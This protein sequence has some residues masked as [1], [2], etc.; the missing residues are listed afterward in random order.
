MC[1]RVPQARH[2]MISI[3]N[4]WLALSTLTS[5]TLPSSMVSTRVTWLLPYKTRVFEPQL[6][7][8]HWRFSASMT[9]ALI[10]SSQRNVLVASPILQV[11]RRLAS[12]QLGAEQRDACSPLSPGRAVGNEYAP[13]PCPR[14]VSPSFLASPRFPRGQR[15]LRSPPNRRGPDP[16]PRVIACL[17]PAT[18]LGREL[19]SRRPVRPR[20][21]ARR[22][23]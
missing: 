17:P 3:S 1:H 7:R 12:S 10:C 9:S 8:G 20:T 13:T 21:P 22:P 16:S 14:S 4:A 11:R 15:W 2:S 18:P 19:I 5:D 23:C 6:S